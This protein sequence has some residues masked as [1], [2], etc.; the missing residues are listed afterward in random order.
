MSSPDPLAQLQQFN[1]QTKVGALA[2]AVVCVIVLGA[3]K[4]TRAYAI[5]IGIVI[6]ALW[7][8]KW[9]RQGGQL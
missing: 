1:A 6:C 8:F 7:F 3:F 4:V 2:A 5:P 9:Q